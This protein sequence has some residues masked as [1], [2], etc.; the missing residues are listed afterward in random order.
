MIFVYDPSQKRMVPR[1]IDSEEYTYK[2]NYDDI[3]EWV[4]RHNLPIVEQS[5][6][7]HVIVDVNPSEWSDLEDDL[8]RNKIPYEEQAIGKTRR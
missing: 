5:Q 4:S 8:Y 7:Y 3:I 2:S 6:G 1:I